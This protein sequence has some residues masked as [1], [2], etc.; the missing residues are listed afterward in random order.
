MVLFHHSLDQ[1]FRLHKLK[2]QMPKIERQN[3]ADNIDSIKLTLVPADYKDKFNSELE[4]YRQQSHMKGFRKG[5]TPMSTIKKMYGKP[6]LGDAV[7]EALQRELGKYISEEVENILLQPLL[8]EDQKE[9]LFNPKNLEEYTFEFEVGLTPEF[10]I[11]GASEA[12]SYEKYVVNEVPDNL[13]D[14]DL[15]AMRRRSGDRIQAEEDI[16]E[17]D[18]V[19]VK[20]QELEGEKIKE[21]GLENEFSLLVESNLTDE[22]K[23]LL[24]SKKL[25]DTFQFNPTALETEMEGDKVRKYFLNVPDEE[26]YADFEINRDFHFEITEVSRVLLA[27]MDEE[28]FKDNFGEEVTD[29]EGARE[30]IAE[31][32][33]GFYE[34]QADILLNNKIQETVLEKNDLDVPETFLKRWMKNSDDKKSDRE[35]DAYYD[36]FRTGV[37]WAAITQKVQK[38]N[39]LEVGEQEIVN[40]VANKISSMYGAYLQGDMLQ[41]FVQRTLQDQNE[42]NRAYEEVLGQKALEQMKSQVTIMENEVTVEE[43]DKIMADIRAEQEKK[44]EEAQAKRLAATVETAAEQKE[45]ET[46]EETAK[47]EEETAVETAD[48]Q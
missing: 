43:M 34:Q 9:V 2:I 35:I 13:I 45:E 44:Q 29:E 23:A 21:E 7:N 19:K 41:N 15:D 26:E 33:K 8:A 31:N 32:I 14:D 16:Q 37:I 12:D 25:G 42:V 10:E 48:N 18:L 24:L 11:Q 4:K 27:E 22:A 1:D 5:K 28:F 20:V 46:Q 47:E 38:A 6:L 17:K 3:I 40:H 39:E 36:D 30:K